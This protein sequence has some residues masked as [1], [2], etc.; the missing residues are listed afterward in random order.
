MAEWVESPEGLGLQVQIPG[1]EVQ[2]WTSPRQVF[3]P[4]LGFKPVSFGFTWYNC[5]VR[6]VFW[7]NENARAGGVPCQEVLAVRSEDLNLRAVEI[8]RSRPRLF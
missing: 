7:K 4:V 3:V 2:T 8:L 1:S 6:G 5:G